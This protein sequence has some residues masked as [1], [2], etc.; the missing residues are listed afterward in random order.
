MR[1]LMDLR[2][3]EFL[4]RKKSA[5]YRINDQNAS[6]GGNWPGANW[7]RYRDSPVS[8]LPFES[9]VA[10][11]YN[12]SSATCVPGPKRFAAARCKRSVINGVTP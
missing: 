12:A 6:T 2:L 10:T 7:M 5:P 1:S 8:G 9:A 11:K 4:Y 3:S